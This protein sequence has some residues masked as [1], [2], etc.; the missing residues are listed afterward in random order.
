MALGAKPLNWLPCGR[1]TGKRR[2]EKAL[3]EV[4]PLPILHRRLFED[5]FDRARALRVRLL[6]RIELPEHQRGAHER[7]REAQSKAKIAERGAEHVLDEARDLVDI[8]AVRA[9]AVNYRKRREASK[10]QLS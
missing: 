6:V 5:P 3:E 4:L 8:K 2:N 10:W 7:S 9:V 1:Y